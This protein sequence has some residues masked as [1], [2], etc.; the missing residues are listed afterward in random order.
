MGIGK[1]EDNSWRCS[2]RGLYS[3]FFYPL[4]TASATRSLPCHLSFLLTVMWST[5]WQ[6]TINSLNSDCYPLGLI[7]PWQIAFLWLAVMTLLISAS[8]SRFE[9]AAFHSLHIHVLQRWVLQSSQYYRLGDASTHLKI[10]VI[11]VGSTWT[12]YNWLRIYAERQKQYYN[13]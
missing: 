8:V 12:L 7:W 11:I 6:L 2:A 9:L 3:L 1:E 13:Q 5:A 4:P 10:K